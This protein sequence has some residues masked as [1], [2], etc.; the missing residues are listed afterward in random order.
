[1][2]FSFIQSWNPTGGS[3]LSHFFLGAIVIALIGAIRREKGRLLNL[4]W[5]HALMFWTGAN[6]AGLVIVSIFR[7]YGN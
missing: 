6:L 7:F 3:G 4:D 2:W 5:K 1:M